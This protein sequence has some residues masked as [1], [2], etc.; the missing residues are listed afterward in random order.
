MA[1]IVGLL[2]RGGGMGAKQRPGLKPGL[3]WKDAAALS[4]CRLFAELLDQAFHS[5]RNLRTHARPVGQAVL[6]DAQALFL[7][8]GAGVVKTNALNETAIATHAP[9]WLAPL[10]RSSI[11]MGTLVA[12]VGNTCRRW[13]KA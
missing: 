7:F 6:R 8:G 11:C 9:A 12:I 13:S 1:L 10:L 5:G 3:A 2:R 4:G